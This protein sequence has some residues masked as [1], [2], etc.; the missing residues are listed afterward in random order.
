MIQPA[1]EANDRGQRM[2]SAS[3]N[4][5]GEQD[6]QPAPLFRRP[7]RDD[8]LELARA[9]FLRGERVDMQQLA[10]Q[11][12][13]SRVTIFRW[14]GSRDQLLE[15]VL[16]DLTSMFLANARLQADGDGEDL[17]LDFVRRVMTA[18]AH[19]EPARQFVVREPQLALRLLLA[20]EG[21][22]H[23]RLAEGLRQVLADA[24]L[25]A[26]ADQLKSFVDVLVQVGT[27]LEWATLAIGDEPQIER[28][29]EIGRALLRAATQ[30]PARSAPP[31]KGKRTKRSS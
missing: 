6:R 4:P 21:V 13:V 3:P 12:D 27:A 26:N 19:F 17:V 16:D 20:E 18:T 15:H 5:G 25:A 22:I 14:V 29:V 30:R 2:A 7:R 24:G 9:A 8:A 11:L 23:R 28:T 31:G 1:T 10:S